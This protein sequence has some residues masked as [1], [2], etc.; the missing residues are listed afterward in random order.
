MA[1]DP[2]TAVLVGDEKKKFDPFNA[3]LVEDQP[4]QPANAPEALA[5]E[6]ASVAQ[7]PSLES[8]INAK[9]GAPTKEEKRQSELS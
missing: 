5:K 7:E 3:T 6:Q 4:E 2:Y 9:R 1:F 8:F